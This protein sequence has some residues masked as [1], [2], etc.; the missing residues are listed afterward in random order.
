MDLKQ[1][2]RNAIEIERAAERFYGMLAARATDQKGRAFLERMARE[3]ELHA[4]GLEERS[5]ELVDGTL[6]A[7]ADRFVHQVE[8]VPDWSNTEA[9]SFEQALSVALEAEQ[10]AELYYDAM[11]DS[12]PAGSLADF[13][14]AMAHNEAAHVQSVASLIAALRG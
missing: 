9:I 13:L 11:A 12:V 14:R 3:E 8:L 5:K 10:H 7:V 1:A 4:R 6:P 2:L